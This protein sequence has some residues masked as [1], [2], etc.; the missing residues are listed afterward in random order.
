MLS[1]RNGGPVVL[2]DFSAWEPVSPRL[3][4]FVSRSSSLAGSQQDYVKTTSVARPLQCVSNGWRD[5]ITT[6]G[7]RTT[8][9]GA[10][11]R[12]AYLRSRARA[13]LSR[14][15]CASVRRALRSA[16]TNCR[17][18]HSLCAH[19]LC[20]ERAVSHMYHADDTS[21]PRTRYDW[22]CVGGARRRVV[23]PLRCVCVYVK[24]KIKKKI[25]RSRA[26]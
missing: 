11:I 18:P 13:S 24:K 9:T 12:R 5:E 7:Q 23:N 22:G 10:N 16:F 19:Q 14:T 15:I 21:V 17:S 20:R 3:W 6:A 2:P 25:R 4:P 8:F 1:R 26:Q